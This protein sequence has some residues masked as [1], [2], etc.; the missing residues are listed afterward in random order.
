MIVIWRRFSMRVARSRKENP[1]PGQWLSPMNQAANR[2]WGSAR[3]LLLGQRPGEHHAAP[4]GQHVL[5]AIELIRDGGALHALALAC[6]PKCFAIA[7]AQRHNTA[8]RVAR[9]DEA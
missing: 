4:A 6:M 3:A 9:E 7:G 2:S 8:L 1:N 5:A